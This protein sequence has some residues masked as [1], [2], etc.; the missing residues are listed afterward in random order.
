[1]V[2]RNCWQLPARFDDRFFARNRRLIIGF[3]R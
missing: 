3:E 2:R 1:M